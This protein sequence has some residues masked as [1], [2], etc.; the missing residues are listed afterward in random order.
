MMRGY[1]IHTAVL[2]ALLAGSAEASWYWPF[3]SDDSD[4]KDPPRLSELMEP[5]SVAIDAATDLMADGKT[6][7]AVEKYREALQA[8]ERI[9]LENPE[10]AATPEFQSV[11]N[12]RAYVD[13]QLNAILLEEARVNA[14]AVAVTDTTELEKQLV[15]KRA[16]QAEMKKAQPV[17][18]QNLAKG[19]SGTPKLE[20]QFD[21]YMEDARERNKTLTRRAA[22][23][24]FERESE[25]KINE[26]LEEDPESRKARLMHAGLEL[27]R[28]NYGT[29]RKEISD[30]LKQDPSDVSALNLLAAI[31]TATGDYSAAETALVKAIRENEGD[32]HAY[33]NL[34]K[35]LVK[36]NNGNDR[37]RAKKLYKAGR[38]SREKDGPGGPEDPYLES[39]F[40]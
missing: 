19:P 32:Y 25:E 40:K 22:T 26:L 33:Y 2:V 27:Y 8:L 34:A 24:K 38:K 12:K 21:T 36:R 17:R 5:A 14:R 15:K 23:A 30:L 6:E 11:R 13:A 31:E 1:F 10:R 28:K 18:E 4:K 39:V 20:K 37:V 9:E 7:E 3:G 16:A 29:A 35:L